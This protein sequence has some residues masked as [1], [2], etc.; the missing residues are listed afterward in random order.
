MDK[1]EYKLEQWIIRDDEQ[2][3]EKLSEYGN[4]GWQ[5]VNLTS[6]VEFVPD[7]EKLLYSKVHT[8]FKFVLMR[9]IKA[10]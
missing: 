3:I 4:N 10:A 7:E 6:V 5:L 1:F 2:L 9:K 8:I